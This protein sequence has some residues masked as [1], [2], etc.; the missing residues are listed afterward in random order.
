MSIMELRSPAEKITRSIVDLQVPQPMFAHL[1]TAMRFSVMP[2]EWPMQTMAVDAKGNCHFNEEFVGKLSLNEL[3]GVLLHEVLH[4]ALTHI[5]RV[6]RRDHKLSNVAQDIVVNSI[7]K[8]AGFELP[9]D[10]IVVDTHNDKCVLEV[11]DKIGNK[12]ITVDKVSEKAWEEVYEEIYNK[13]P[14]SNKPGTGPG[15]GKGQGSGAGNEEREWVPKQFDDH[16]H[17]DTNPQEAAK[18]GDEWKQK[19]TDAATYAKQQGKLPNGMDRIID[20]LLKPRVEWHT[21]LLK[22][23]REHVNPV[24]WSYRAP[25]KKS[26]Q[27]GVFLPRVEKESCEIEVIIDTSGSIGSKELESFLSEVVGMA[28]AMSYMKMYVTFVDAEAYEDARYEVENGDIPK[29]L[30]M[31][32]KGGGGT[33]MEAGLDFVKE[34]NP[35]TPVTIVLT[36][37]YTSFNKTAKD[38]PFDVI[39]VLTKDS[40]D[41]K[42]VP[43]GIVIKMDG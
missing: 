40:V 12:S 36:D 28:Q 6:G 30:A 27:L 13:L 8:R 41:P 3:K 29:I 5:S 42:K 37:G 14:K 31:K 2:K 23:V 26:K 18:A 10:A 34:K 19:L 25:H 39:W 21:I 7:V 17:G 35:S 1:L 11:P 15:K 9:D 38:Y 24:D 33:D 4:V 16:R 20:K 22:Y 32:P 43:Y